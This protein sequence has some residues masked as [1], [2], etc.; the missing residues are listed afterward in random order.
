M[1]PDQYPGEQTEGY[2]HEQNLA[3]IREIT[4]FGRLWLVPLLA[5]LFATAII[6]KLSG[7]ISWLK[8]LIDL[9]P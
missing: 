4:S 1:T 2:S 9:P 3:Y 8:L 7:G 5:I 6:F